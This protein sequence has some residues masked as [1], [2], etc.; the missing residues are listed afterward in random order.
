MSACAGQFVAVRSQEELRKLIFVC[1]EE[2]T[3]LIPT[4]NAS[5]P[6]LL[7][8]ERDHCVVSLAELDEVVS[9][10]ADDLTMTVGVGATIDDIQRIV[11]REGQ[12][13]AV[14]VPY[15]KNTAVGSLVGMGTSGFVANAYG[16]VAQQVLGI[17][18]YSGDGRRL[19]GGGRVVKNVTGYDFVR[20]LCG[21]A[22]SLGIITEVTFRLRPLPTVESTFV[23]HAKTLDV[24]IEV[25]MGL[26]ESR[27]LL[28]AVVVVAGTALHNPS[29]GPLVFVRAEG[30]E[31][32]MAQFGES[33]GQYALPFDQVDG[34]ESEALWQEVSRFASSQSFHLQLIMPP[35]AVSLATQ[36]L[37]AED[38]GSD[39]GMVIDIERAKISYCTSLTT[40]QELN[41]LDVI[42]LERNH[43][44]VASLPDDL[45]DREARWD[46]FTHP[47]A[48][49]RKIGD[50]IK[51]AF[52]PSGILLPLRPIAGSF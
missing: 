45:S 38:T 16:S 27:H 37:L 28:T 47:E 48:G 44:A 43:R 2:G 35:S 42:K 29:G 40:E 22:G 4:S 13:L 31:D 24:G 36:A 14:E 51:I 18:A 49:A 46:R 12:R 34:E 3:P 41:R 20:L 50:R 15:P 21:S 1:A 26:R 39:W 8:G 10:A 33:L 9:Y 19:V 7:D 30:S 52:D 6:P 17:E 23:I 32:S 25:A 5:M 11:G